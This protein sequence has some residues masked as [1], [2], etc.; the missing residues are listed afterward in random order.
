VTSLI[1][2]RWGGQ[3]RTLLQLEEPEPGVVT[4]IVNPESEHAPIRTGTF[5]AATGAL[6]L[7][8]D[9]ELDGARTPF[10]IEGRLDGES[11]HAAYRFGELAGEVTLARIADQAPGVTSMPEAH[12]AASAELNSLFREA[13]AAIDAGNQPWL[14]RLLAAHPALVR[15]R[16]D[17]PG[18]WLRRS[19]GG[20]LDGFFARPYLL[21]FLSEDAVRAGTLPPNAAHLARAIIEAAR[22]HGVE[23][24]Q[25]QIDYA[26]KLVAWS[27]VAH[28]SGVQIELI[29]TLIDAGASPEGAGDG[30]LVNGLTDAVAHLVRRGASVTL[31]IALC[32]ERWADVERLAK[33]ASPRERRMAFVLA[34]LNGRADALRRMV[35]LG[36]DVNAKSEDLYAHATPLHHAVC[37]GSLEAVTALVEAGADLKTKDTAWDATP[38]GWAEHYVEERETG[39]WRA[40]EAYLRA[41]E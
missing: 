8:G 25:E 11:L 29:D 28:R 35:E 3:G 37:S 7:E 13:L 2:G 20:A 14:E 19:S 17:S 27:G 21:W 12:D 9:A 26:L 38:L 40:I 34:A 31:G 30:A 24:L 32:L 33:T 18:E 4:G 22:Q 16:L 39:N 1:A 36:A 6:K 41:R 5:D 15:D 23:S 10:V